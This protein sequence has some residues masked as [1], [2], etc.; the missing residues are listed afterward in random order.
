MG[1]VEL[2]VIPFACFG[3]RLGAFRAFDTDK[4]GRRILWL[5]DLSICL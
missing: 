5:G 2:Q 4:Y 1:G 3:G